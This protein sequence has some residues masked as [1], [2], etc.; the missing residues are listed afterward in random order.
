MSLYQDKVSQNRKAQLSS[1]WQKWEVK[2]ESFLE[3]LELT[4]QLLPLACYLLSLAL[5]CFLGEN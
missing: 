3:N 4:R 2:K 1:L 5:K